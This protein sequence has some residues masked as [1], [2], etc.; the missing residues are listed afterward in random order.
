MLHLFESGTLHKSFAIFLHEIFVYYPSFAYLFNNLY[1]C[2]V[3][4]QQFFI[5]CSNCSS[6]G[7]WE[8]FKLTL[9][10]FFFSEIFYFLA[11]CS[12]L[13]SAFSVLALKQPFFQGC[14]VLF[15]EECYQTPRS[16]SWLCPLLL[17][18]AAIY[19]HLLKYFL[20]AS[21]LVIMNKTVILMQVFM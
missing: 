13:S 3:I 17:D 8:L 21:R 20:V 9:C 11:L 7:L 4:I 6:F 15:I 16:G 2:K 1:P 12:I 10:P 18:A 19:I 14:L 5:C